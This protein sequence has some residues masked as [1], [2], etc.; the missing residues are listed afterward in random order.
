[1]S[2]FNSASEQ[3]IIIH[4]TSNKRPSKKGTTSLQNTLPIPRKG[5]ITICNTFQP[6]KRGQPPYKDKMA[7]FCT[8][9]TILTSETRW[10]LFVDTSCFEGTWIIMILEGISFCSGIQYAIR[11]SVGDHKK[12]L[13]NQHMYNFHLLQ[14]YVKVMYSFTEQL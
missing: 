11:L 8:Y 2:T 7:G 13:E 4:G 6:P 12:S 3:K 14:F 10:R 5:Y 9:V 1:M